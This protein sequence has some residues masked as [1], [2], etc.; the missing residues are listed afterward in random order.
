MP[1]NVWQILVEP[2]A[3]VEAGDRLVIL[4][5]MKMEISITAPISGKVIEV[6]CRSGQMVSSGQLLFVI[7]IL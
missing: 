7:Q 2:D 1:A 6:L 5:S 4:E 3:I